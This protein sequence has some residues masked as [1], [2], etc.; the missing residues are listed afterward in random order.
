MRE[1]FS[2][3][4][5]SSFFSILLSSWSSAVAPSP[6]RKV[7]HEASITRAS[8]FPSRGLLCSAYFAGSKT[9]VCCITPTVSHTSKNSPLSTRCS[10]RRDLLSDTHIY[11]PFGL[12]PSHRRSGDRFSVSSH[13]SYSVTLLPLKPPVMRLPSKSRER[14]ARILGQRA[15]RAL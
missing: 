1:D 2:P 15:I 13:N 14:I 3:M 9:E 4:T 5:E 12:S 6:K 7:T 8:A 11:R 10:L